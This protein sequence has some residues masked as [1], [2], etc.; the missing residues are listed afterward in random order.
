[1][2]KNITTFSILIV[3]LICGFVS[4]MYAITAQTN[5]EYYGC[6]NGSQIESTTQVD[7]DSD[8]IYD[9]FVTKW[10]PPYAPK[11]YPVQYGFKGLD[12]DEL[13]DEMTPRP[14]NQP[15][16]PPKPQPK[17]KAKIMYSNPLT[18]SF[19]EVVYEELTGKTLWW[20]EKTDDQDFVLCSMPE[21]LPR[22]TLNENNGTTSNSALLPDP[23][24]NEVALYFSVNE[25]NRVT[26]N[27][28]NQTGMNVAALYDGQKSA[29]QHQVNFN[30]AS[31]P[32]GLYFVQSK[33]GNSIFTQKLLLAK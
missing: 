6:E 33:I 9:T 11:T 23:K 17:K 5:I 3:L 16:P 25:N 29:G 2:K 13:E 28:Y 1:M 20:W 21:V 31:L 26:I 14:W 15:Q 30:T 27:V 12:R 4:V 19:K 24:T 7:T 32:N 10:C 22:V 8:G 18:G